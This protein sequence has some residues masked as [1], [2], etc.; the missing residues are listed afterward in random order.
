MRLV[1]RAT[2]LTNFRRPPH[3]VE[4]VPRA[5][6]AADFTWIATVW[7]ACWRALRRS[8]P[9]TSPDHRL[10]SSVRVGDVLVGIHVAP[11]EPPFRTHTAVRTCSCSIAFVSATDAGADRMFALHQRDAREIWPS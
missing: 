6:I 9:W 3:R 11:W 5:Y 2:R 7:S 8:S 10:A 1:A 4:G